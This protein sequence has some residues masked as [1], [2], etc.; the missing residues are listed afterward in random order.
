VRLPQ[1]EGLAHV[2][3]QEEG[4]P[5]IPPVTGLFIGTAEVCAF[6][7]KLILRQTVIRHVRRS[8][9]QPMGALKEILDVISSDSYLVLHARYPL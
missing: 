6:N 9:G 1:P 5:I 2:F 4:S 8:V 7:L 3:F